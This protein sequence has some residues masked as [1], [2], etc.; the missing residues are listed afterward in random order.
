[1]TIMEMLGQSGVLT[2]LGIGVVFG[3]L[4]ILVL[5]ISLLGKIIRIK[6][7][8]TELTTASAASSLPAATDE[9]QITAA[10]TAA[11]K[12]YRGGK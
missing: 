4:F 10:I 7:T 8:D 6:G 1:M 2:L 12:Q 5:T 9:K 3:F 11:L